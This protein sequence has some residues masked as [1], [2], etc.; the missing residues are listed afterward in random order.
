VLLVLSAVG[1]ALPAQMV[2]DSPFAD[3]QSLR[4]LAIRL[5]FLFENPAD[6]RSGQGQART[7]A[8]FWAG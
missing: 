3:L 6:R 8:G 5:L 7:E 2:T 1:L 4:N